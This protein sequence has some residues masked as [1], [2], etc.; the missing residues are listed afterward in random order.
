MNNQESE[1]PFRALIRL[2]RRGM[3]TI[4]RDIRHKLH[5]H[6]GQSMVVR[7]QD[8]RRIVIEILPALNPDDLFARY[9]IQELIND[10]DW[11][12][13]MADAMARQQ[14]REDTDHA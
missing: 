5:L 12:A 6:E 13:G 10:A 3:V 4:P 1:V 14:E 11:H 8:E 2:Q 7:I 9:P